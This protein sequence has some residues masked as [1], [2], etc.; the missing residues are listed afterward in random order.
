[1][2][3]AAT[4]NKLVSQEK[5]IVARNIKINGWHETEDNK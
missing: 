4:P 1:M 2:G 3:Y 5:A